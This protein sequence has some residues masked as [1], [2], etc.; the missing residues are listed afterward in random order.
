MTVAGAVLLLQLV[1]A[2][3]GE[4]FPGEDAAALERLSASPSAL[5]LLVAPQPLSP[6]L[7]S[8]PAPIPILRMPEARPISRNERM[9][10][11]SLTFSTQAAAAFDARTTRML[12]HGYGGREVNPF[13]R[14]VA[15]SDAGLFA[16]LQVSASG[17]NYLG[18]RMLRSQR[19]W[20][21]KLWW[22]PQTVNV[23]G[24][25]FGGFHNLNEIHKLQ[26][27]GVR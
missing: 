5:A 9:V 11:T 3:P 26:N 19:R 12:L 25:L 17:A 7:V 6:P 4:E 22:L 24:S 20:V 8:A 13:L 27:R 15:G 14:P 2:L 16:A 10:W 18:W 1:A 21:R 23:A